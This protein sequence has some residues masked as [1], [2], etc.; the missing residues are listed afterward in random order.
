MDKEA[1]QQQPHDGSFLLDLQWL[2]W[3]DGIKCSEENPGML[4]WLLGAFVCSKDGSY[5]VDTAEDDGGL[6]GIEQRACIFDKRC[7]TAMDNLEYSIQCMQQQFYNH[8]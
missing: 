1:Y 7:R 6:D 8:G 3:M 5:H 2:W 4:L